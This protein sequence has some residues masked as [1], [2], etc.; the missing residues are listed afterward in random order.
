MTADITASR[1]GHNPDTCIRYTRAVSD[2][3]ILSG[4]T[5]LHDA[6]ERG[7][8]RVEERLMRRIE[9]LE[10]RAIRLERRIERAEAPLVRARTKRLAAS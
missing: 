7:F 1:I 3:E 8:A 10:A 2:D 6:I 4:F 9:M 5:S